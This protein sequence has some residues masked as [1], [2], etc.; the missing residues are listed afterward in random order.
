MKIIFNFSLK[1]LLKTIVNNILNALIY[2]KIKYLFISI[3]IFLLCC[4]LIQSTYSQQVNGIK[5]RI[6]LTGNTGDVEDHSEIYNSLNILLSQYNDPFTFLINGDLISSKLDDKAYGKDSTRIKELLDAV[7]SFKNGKVVIVPGD[8]DWADSQ[9]GGLKTVRK[10]E[11]LVKSF[12]Y[13]NVKWS[14]KKGCP[15]PKK[16]K[17]DDDIILLTL[18]TQWWNHPFDKPRPSDADCKFATTEGFKE[19]FEDIID[20]NQDKNIIIA[21][22]FPI[23][24]YGEN[25]GH[26]PIE[27]HIFPLIDLNEYLYIPLPIIGNFYPSYRENI[28]TQRDI[29]NENYENF[30]DLLKNIVT[31]KSSLIYVS[32]NDRNLQ[33]I[34]EG[35]NYY[36]NSGSPRKYDYAGDGPGVL[37]SESLPGLIELVFYNNGKITANVYELSKEEKL[38]IVSTFELYREPGFQV[39]EDEE[40]PVNTAFQYKLNSQ[41]MPK[42]KTGIYNDS[43]T[44]IAG[45]EYE[46]GSIHR[47]FF[48]DH[49][50]D[51]WTAKVTVPYLNLDTTF[52]GLT[53]LKK[54]GGRQTTSLKFIGGNGNKYVFRSVNKDPIKALEYKY[55]KTLLAEILRDQTTTQHPYGAVAIDVLLNQT[56][57]KHAHPTLYVLPDDEK[58]GPF[59]EE[60]AN[61]FGMLEEFP[62]NAVEDEELIWNADEIVKSNKLFRRLYDDHDN[63]VNINKFALA[64]VFDILVGDW[65]KHED[66]WKWA[67]YKKD[68]GMLY[69]P[70]PRDR[71]HVFSNWDG[72]FPWLA[73][74]EW[75]KASGENFDYEI[76][77]LRSLM[78]QARHLDRFIG[79]E[80]SK[81]DWLKA[82]E[83][84]QKSITDEVIEEAISGMPPE[85][86][87]ISGKEIEDKLKVRRDDLDK[88]A[89]EYYLM[90]AKEVD[91]V[92]SNK[93]E[94]FEVTRLDDGKVEVTIFN[95][96]RDKENKKGTNIYYHRIFN[97]EET[98]EIRLFGL[99]GTDIFEIKGDVENSI[100][101]RIIGGPGNDI[102]VDNSNVKFGGSM[103]LIYE[104]SKDAEID[105]GESSSIVK[106]NNKAVYNYNRTAFK[107]NEYFPSPY[108]AYS[109]DLQFVLSFGIQFISRKYGKDPYNILQNIRATYATVGSFVLNY[110]VLFNHALGNWNIGLRGLYANPTSFTYFYGI[111][112]ETEIDQDLFNNDYYRTRY[113]AI[114]FAFEIGNDFWKVSNF[115]IG[116]SYENNGEQLDTINTIIGDGEFFGTDNTSIGE[117][118]LALDIDFRNNASFPERGMRFYIEQDFGLIFS[119]DN[120][121]Y[122]KT[123]SFIEMFITRKILLPITLG[124]RIGGGDSYGDIPFYKQFSLGQNNYLRG[125][126]ANRF[127]GESILF[128]NTELRL[129]LSKI[130][131]AIAP[132]VIGIKGFFDTGKVIQN[133]VT[134]KIWHKGY[135]FGIFII[136][137]EESLTL[138][139]TFGYSEEESALIQFQLGKVF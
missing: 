102:I 73:D 137:L 100:L 67:G 70:I 57:I 103:T 59:R 80:L 131:T 12:G 139:F 86:Y 112:N 5:H 54:G 22:H 134:S 91:I 99:G 25:G 13:K 23:I 120:S 28:G 92:G 135:G 110:S 33:I 29:V 82:A 109:N 124:I 108:I 127:T 66:N 113:R 74:R 71:D 111:G 128:L 2:I 118:V 50:R 44:V 30:R 97:P 105:L 7:A 126:R 117:A 79:S 58:L 8:R 31:H 32:G 17:I 95:V 87:N 116:V 88:Y 72:V 138:D 27:K 45:K 56:E 18:N 65:G 98:S 41:S 19:E 121:N 90:L 1:Q 42:I 37:Y 119:N 69:E 123:F 60:F 43:V 115:S 96:D 125:Y 40:I 89:L 106:T 52:G 75:A 55:R 51:T 68:I 93:K 14:I 85:V 114:Q 83:I 4:I 107:Y 34:K 11:K 101:L 26:M 16:I 20:E 122:G 132:V 10:L 130:K 3:I 61:L 64:R 35:T 21:G 46:S 104:K 49:Y 81:K 39:N 63:E 78:Y 38:T 76:S 47:F 84:L 53:V 24:S 15:G 136:P 133:E 48:G 77:G 62:S 6:Y 36:I 9:K 129:Q 94:Y